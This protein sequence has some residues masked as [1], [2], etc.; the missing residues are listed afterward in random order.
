M[1]TSVGDV[2]FGGVLSKIAGGMMRAGN[3]TCVA[4]G[5]TD[6]H[7]QSDDRQMGRQSRTPRDAAVTKGIGYPRARAWPANPRFAPEICRLPRSAKKQADFLD[8]S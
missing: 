1:A 3:G 4:C 7:P 6:A 2:E 8:S 5:L